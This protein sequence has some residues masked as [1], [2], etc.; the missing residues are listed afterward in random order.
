ME[1]V[2]DKLINEDGHCLFSV[3]LL[4]HCLF[5][6]EQ[7]TNKRGRNGEEWRNG[8]QGLGNIGARLEGLLKQI[9]N[10]RSNGG[11]WQIQTLNINI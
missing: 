1:K 11:D 3:G 9:G 8:G 5:L 7:T 6:G 4:R 10:W 2:H